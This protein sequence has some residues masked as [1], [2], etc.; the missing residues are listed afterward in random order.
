MKVIPKGRYGPFYKCE[1]CNSTAN[2]RR[3]D[4]DQAIVPEARTCP[5]CGKEMEI[6][7]SKTGVFLGC[8]GFRDKENQC[9]YTRPL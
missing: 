7:R 6:R 5:K 4:L 8:A 1:G 3:G 2:I 9:K